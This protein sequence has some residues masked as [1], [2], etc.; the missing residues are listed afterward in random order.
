MEHSPIGADVEHLEDG[1]AAQLVH[2]DEGREP[3]P[4][5]DADELRRVLGADGAVLHVDY[6]VVKSRAG[7]RLY[8][9]R[10]EKMRE[11]AEAVLPGYVLFEKAVSH[12]LPP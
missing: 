11:G 10:A 12:L 5:G 1:A 2:A 7:Q 9:G 3:C 4:G 8:R 6:D